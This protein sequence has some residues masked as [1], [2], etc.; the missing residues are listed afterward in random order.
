MHTPPFSVRDP[1]IGAHSPW[2]VIAAVQAHRALVW[3]NATA[4][5][6]LLPLKDA[7]AVPLTT[8]RKPPL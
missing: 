7:G 3:G 4:V 2:V 1:P 5:G 8:Q 6:H